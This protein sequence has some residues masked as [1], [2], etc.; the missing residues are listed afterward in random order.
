MLWPII[1]P[2][3]RVDSWNLRFET[4]YA[5]TPEQALGL[6]HAL[7]HIGYI[8]PRKQAGEFS[9]NSSALYSFTTLFEQLREC[10]ILQAEG[11]SQ[12]V[13]SNIPEAFVVKQ[14]ASPMPAT[15]DTAG[16]LFGVQGLDKIAASTFSPQPASSLRQRSTAASSNL[17]SN[18]DS[19]SSSTR[20]LFQVE[21]QPSSPRRPRSSP[22]PAAVSNVNRW[23]AAPGPA[24]AF[25]LFLVLLILLG[26][27]ALLAAPLPKPWPNRNLLFVA[28]FAGWVLFLKTLDLS[29]SAS[30]HGPYLAFFS[31]SCL[32]LLFLAACAQYVL[33]RHQQPPPPHQPI[34]LEGVMVL[35]LSALVAIAFSASSS[36]RQLA[37]QLGR[38]CIR[39]SKLPV[40]PL[41]SADARYVSY[42]SP[43][44]SPS[45]RLEAARRER[46]KCNRERWGVASASKNSAFMDD[47][48]ED[49]AEAELDS[50]LRSFLERHS[51][52]NDILGQIKV[53]G[54]GFWALSV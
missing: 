36:I 52:G 38:K 39:S 5:R 35:V 23:L 42:S 12:S 47:G 8:L 34:L 27:V 14:A 28:Y 10:Q 2:I 18:S 21:E 15:P 4:E 48:G 11:V 22:V 49:E 26:G 3:P 16:K 44:A 24:A 29:G 13:Q 51:L 43:K 30:W 31:V 1:L 37:R 33:E 45:T 53:G 19:S 20:R 50:R 41:F 7:M 32:S 17:K 9:A 40:D 46:A 25:V 6:C 54:L